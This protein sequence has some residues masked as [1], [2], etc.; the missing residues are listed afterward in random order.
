MTCS[1]HIHIAGRGR[2]ISCGDGIGRWVSWSYSTA[3]ACVLCVA[4]ARALGGWAI[5]RVRR[6]GVERASDVANVLARKR[7]E[8]DAS[9][10]AGKASAGGEVE[11]AEVGELE[12]APDVS[13]RGRRRRDPNRG[14]EG[15]EVEDRGRCGR[16][17]GRR[18]RR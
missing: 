8:G 9:H 13:A 17:W 14:R 18:R 1:I 4:A 7:R 6:V 3:S 2:R 5:E 16:G 10:V 15:R 12:R 11:R